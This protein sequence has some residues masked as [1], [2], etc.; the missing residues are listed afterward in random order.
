MGDPL[1]STYG[2]NRRIGDNERFGPLQ[3]R[4]GKNCFHKSAAAMLTNRIF[5]IVMLGKIIA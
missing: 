5:R 4:A 3:H 1:R 2:R